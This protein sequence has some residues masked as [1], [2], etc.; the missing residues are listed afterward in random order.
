MKQMVLLW[1]FQEEDDDDGE[2]EEEEGQGAGPKEAGQ[3]HH[4]HHH[5]HAHTGDNG[6]VDMV[7]QQQQG[8]YT[9]EVK[10]E[11]RVI[12]DSLAIF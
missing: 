6:H 5:H 9:V 8:A 4:H 10:R 3:A 11:C 12:W 2:E 1:N 7:V